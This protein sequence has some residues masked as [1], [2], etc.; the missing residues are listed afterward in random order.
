MWPLNADGGTTL[1]RLALPFGARSPWEKS[2]R[3]TQRKATKELQILRRKHEES[4]T[5]LAILMAGVAALFLVGIVAAY[6]YA[7]STST[8]E[9]PATASAPPTSTG[10]AAKAPTMPAETTGAGSAERGAPA[11]PKKTQ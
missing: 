3:E 4:N 5:M 10:P 7:S 1:S 8:V 9:T 2:M 6:N 11:Q